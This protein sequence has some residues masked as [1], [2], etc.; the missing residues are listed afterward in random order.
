VKSLVARNS[1]RGEIGSVYSSSVYL[2]SV[3]HKT[4]PQCESN[5]FSSP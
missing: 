2:C 3:R 1:K 4:W 5:A